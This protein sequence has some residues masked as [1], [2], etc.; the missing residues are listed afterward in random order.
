MALSSQ[1]ENSPDVFTDYMMVELTPIWLKKF[2]ITDRKICSCNLEILLKD[3]QFLGIFDGTE[4]APDAQDVTQLK[5]RKMLYRITRE[6][7]HFAIGISRQHQDGVKQDG[8]VCRNQLKQD[9]KL[10]VMPNV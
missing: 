1:S 9:Y 5:A 3:I 4:K 8:K 7:I 2:G 6:I 10:K